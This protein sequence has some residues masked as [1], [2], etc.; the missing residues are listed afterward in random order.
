MKSISCRRA[1]LSRDNFT[2]N[3]TKYA[4]PEQRRTGA[5]KLR[6]KS[7]PRA[8]IYH[9]PSIAQPWRCVRVGVRAYFSFTPATAVAGLPARL[10]PYCLRR[11]SRPLL[12]LDRSI[13]PGQNRPSATWKGGRDQFGLAGRLRWHPHLRR[14]L[15]DYEDARLRIWGLE[16]RVFP[17]APVFPLRGKAFGTFRLSS[18]GCRYGASHAIPT[19]G[20]SPSRLTAPASASPRR[21]PG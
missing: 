11:S 13:T 18:D 10:R 21:P 6:G 3:L 5:A 19:N 20:A 15:L 1:G 2:K 12:W 16:V 9:E 8:T 14:L 17:G 7:E 4:V